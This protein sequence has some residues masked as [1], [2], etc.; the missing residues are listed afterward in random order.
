[1]LRTTS[2]III[3]SLLA[4]QGADR[5]VPA[6]DGNFS[7]AGPV[8]TFS[9]PIG[10]E[11]I[12]GHA[13]WD[14]W[15]DI[16]EVGYQEE[17]Y[18]VS[19]SARSHVDDSVAEYTSRVIVRRPENAADFNGTVLLDWVNVTAQFENAVDTLEAHRFFLRE[20]YAFVHLSAQAA[21]LCCTPLTPQVWDPVRYAEL[22]HPGDDYAFDMVSQ[23]ARAFKVV[24]EVNPMA[25]LQTQR[26]IAMGQSQS[27]IQL[28][29]Y[30]N[31]VQASAQA[32]DG[33]LV[34]GDIGAGKDFGSRPAAPVL[35]LLSDAEA[36]P[37]EPTATEN[38]VLWEVAGTA[39][40]D[41]WVGYHQELGQARRVVAQLPKMSME[42]DDQLHVLAAN[43]GEVPD[44]GLNVCVAAGAAFPMRYAVAAGLHHLHH[45]LRDGIKPP[46]PPRYEFRS[47]N[48]ATDDLGNALG[49]LRYPPID[50]PIARYQSTLCQLG[51]ITIPLTEIELLQRYPTH[52]DYMAALSSATAQ[53]VSDGYLLTADA[54]ELLS[55]AQAASLRWPVDLL[56]GNA[57]P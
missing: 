36:E 51:G 50:V 39:H 13:M 42:Q 53:S 27:A 41:L 1:M 38:Y 10:N 20:G 29:Q 15:Y 28:H 24:A 54:K 3:L 26:V 57:S 40:Q 31:E 37:E 44:P 23:I 6:G 12:F 7:I 52:T 11:G 35:H 30:I 16:G 45:W 18:F 33:F 4:C 2:L 21:G 47:G 14:T 8:A 49:G 55:R 17:E 43:Y 56:L 25:G 22:N 46:Q 19:G 5:G 34:H 32:I 48:L 9:G